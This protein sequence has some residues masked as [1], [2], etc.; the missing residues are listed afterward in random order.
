[1]A[2][3][4][5]LVLSFAALASGQRECS[6]LLSSGVVLSDDYDRSSPPP[7][8]EIDGKV[9][10]QREEALNVINAVLR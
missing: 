6:S 1:M 5:C 8:I 2:K 4:A 3:S 9:R 7:Q 10:L